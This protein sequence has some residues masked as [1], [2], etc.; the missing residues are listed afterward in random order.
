M[1]RQLLFI[2]MLTIASAA[3]AQEFNGGVSYQYISATQWNKIIQTYNFSRPFVVQKQPL[4]SGG[5]CVSFTKLF[6]THKNISKGVSVSYALMKSKSVNENFINTLNLHFVNIGY[7]IRYGDIGKQKAAFGEV[8]FSAITSGLFRNVND[9]S[10]IYDDAK[11]KAFGIGGNINLKVGYWFD[12]SKKLDC[13]PYLTV[14]YC[15]YLYSPNTETVINETRGLIGKDHT[16]IINAQI[17][18]M[19]RKNSN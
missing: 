13:A 10:F 11:S 2:L 18:L 5:G 6:T 7:T 1:T 16:G 14:G 15:P 8:T 19:I 4:F 9:A 12:V 3:N 17:G